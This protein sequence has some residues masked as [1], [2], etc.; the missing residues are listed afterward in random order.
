MKKEMK[1]KLLLILGILLFLLII[2]YFVLLPI[3]IRYTETF[4]VV[5]LFALLIYL[6]FGLNV[7]KKRYINVQNQ[8]VLRAT[9]NDKAAY[10]LIGAF[11]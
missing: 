1:W 7:L 8:M 2:N 3:N 10:V 11:Q 4:I 9:I 6:L 5:L